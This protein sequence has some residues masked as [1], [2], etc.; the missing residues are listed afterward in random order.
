MN[1]RSYL[2]IVS[3]GLLLMLATA[4]TATTSDRGSEND[5]ASSAEVKNKK[6]ASCAS[7][8]GVC[9]AITPGACA[10]GAWA[11]AT[12]VSCGGGLGVGCCV[13]PSPPPPPPPPCPSLSPPTPGVCH[14]GTIDANKDAN[15]CTT[16]YTCNPGPNACAAAG[17]ACVG[18]SPGSCPSGN[19]ADYSSHPC[20]TGV[21]VGCCLP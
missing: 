14:G 18:V 7:V 1:T 6:K 8:G 15:G 13:E 9:V 11:D 5:G 3:F 20:G 12:A 21:G 19:W 4:C 10:D 16:G 2:G 17:G